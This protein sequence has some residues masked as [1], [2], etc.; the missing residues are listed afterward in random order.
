MLSGV[1]NARSRF[2]PGAF[3]PV[4]LNLVMIAGIAIGY[5]LREAG[6]DDV[7]VAWSLAVALALAGVAQLGYMVWA[8]RKAR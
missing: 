6:G 7:T 4:F 8:C 1:L 5:Y 3:V 2:A